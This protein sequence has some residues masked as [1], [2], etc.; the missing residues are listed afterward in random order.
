MEP[1]ELI[2]KIWGIDESNRKALE[3]VLQNADPK[4]LGLQLMNLGASS[5]DE[6][7]EAKNN[8]WMETYL[9]EFRFV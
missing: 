9:P 8:A 1:I 5:Q 3:D 4:Y 2:M 7:F 6:G